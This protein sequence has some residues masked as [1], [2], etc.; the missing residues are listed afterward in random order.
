M[1]I[2][3]SELDEECLRLQATAMATGTVEGRAIAA[4]EDSDVQLVPL[5]F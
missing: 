1:D 5:A 3:V 4:E 2:A